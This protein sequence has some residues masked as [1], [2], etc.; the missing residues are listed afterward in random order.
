MSRSRRRPG[1]GCW[2]ACRAAAPS[3][4]ST[5]PR[6]GEDLVAAEA[7]ARGRPPS[8]ARDAAA[9]VVG[10]GPARV[11]VVALRASSSACLPRAG[12]VA[13]AQLLGDL[14]L[15]QVGLRQH[16]EPLAQVRA[17]ARTRRCAWSACSPPRRPRRARAARRGLE[18]QLAGRRAG[19][20]GRRRTGR[21]GVGRGA[22]R[23]RLVGVGASRASNRRASRPSRP[24]PAAT[25]ST[26]PDDVVEVLAAGEHLADRVLLG[27]DV[28]LCPSARRR[29]RAPC[30]P[31]APS[32]PAREH[33]EVAGELVVAGS[34]SSVVI[35]G[36]CFWP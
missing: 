13:S 17:A 3:G 33:P 4:S 22:S 27:L 34:S 9:K 29:R 2:S 5:S 20:R 28:V 24:S 18:R 30:A 25:S 6:D 16:L 11:V 35:R 10:L 19:R 12:V 7:P 23:R 14:A 36:G 1:R 15:A 31:R 8:R 21:S 26:R 32:R